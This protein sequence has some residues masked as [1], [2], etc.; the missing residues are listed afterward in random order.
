M[1][2]LVPIMYLNSFSTC[3]P[4]DQAPEMDCMTYLLCQSQAAWSHLQRSC[5][6]EIF[7]RRPIEKLSVY[8]DRDSAPGWSVLSWKGRCPEDEATLSS[9]DAGWGEEGHPVVALQA[10][11]TVLWKLTSGWLVD[12]FPLRFACVWK[13]QNQSSLMIRYI[14]SV[15]CSCPVG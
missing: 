10:S 6:V 15:T 5:P 12:A 9:V 14:H 3:R 4:P 7:S 13:C 1:L 2:C 11:T 8:H